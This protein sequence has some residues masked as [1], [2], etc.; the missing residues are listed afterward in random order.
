[1]LAVE[2][3]PIRV[4]IRLRKKIER[5]SE[6][7]AETAQMNLLDFAHREEENANAMIDRFEAVVMV[8]LD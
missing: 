1:M 4:W 6:A 3:D 5:R 2:D 8:C 7:E